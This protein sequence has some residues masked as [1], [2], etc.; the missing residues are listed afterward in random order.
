VGANIIDGIRELE[1]QDP[2]LRLKVVGSKNPES[3]QFPALVEAPIGENRNPQSKNKDFAAILQQGMGEQGG[4][5]M[6]KYCYVDIGLDTDVHSLFEAYRKQS[7][8]MKQQYPALAIVHVTVP[9]TTYEM[10]LRSWAKAA[11]GRPTVRDVA[12]KRNE[13]NQLLRAT[14]LGKEPIFDLA[15]VES[16]A[17]DGSRSYFMRG[18]EK[19]YTLTPSYAADDGHLNQLGRRA[20]ALRMLQVLSEL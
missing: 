11:L 5:A 18:S 10:D 13:F 20:A 8:L 17:P 1:D 12:A 19:I 7:D 3:V 9:L 15:E 4:I 2:R 6:Y 14:Y 16:T